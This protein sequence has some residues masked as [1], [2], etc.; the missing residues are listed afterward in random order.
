MTNAGKLRYDAIPIPETLDSVICEAVKKGARRTAGVITMRWLSAAAA[1]FAIFFAC[2]NIA[3][4]YAFAQDIPVIGQIVRVLR[5]GSGG[6]IT[7]GAR[8]SSEVSDGGTVDIVFSG[9][10][11]GNAS[12]PVYTVTHE[13]APNRFDLTLSG[14]R[15][16]DYGTI[17]SDLRASAAVRDVY[18]MMIG[19]D[20]MLG[21][22]VVMN[23]GYD[24]EITEH[25]NP[26][27]LSVR[28]FRAEDYDASKTVW[29][30]RS[31]AVEYG[32]ELMMLSDMYYSEGATQVRT[33]G[34]GYII[35]AGQYETEDEA[36]AAL[37]GIRKNFGDE[38]GLYVSSGTADEVPEK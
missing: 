10:D 32:E 33:A 11:A 22:V 6:E 1:A 38:C 37:A 5:V 34:G 29:Y 13:Y 14:A 36:K 23:S 27:S 2:A 8:A 28:F 17:E 15:G 16:M 12:A 19:D 9:G 21:I 4:V 26:A 25:A 3:P 18:Q 35:A 7:D 30:L 20:S 31:D 24:Y